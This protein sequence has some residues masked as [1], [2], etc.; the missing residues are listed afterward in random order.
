MNPAEL[1]VDPQLR[2]ALAETAAVAAGFGSPP[3]NVAEGRAQ[4]AAIRCFWNEGGP[5][6]AERSE[7]FVPGPLRQIPVVV[8]RSV[9]G[10]HPR[11]PVFVYLHG[12]GFKTGNAWANDRQMR[13]LCVAWGGTVISADYA[14]AP[15]HVF[16]AAVDETVALLSWLNE[17]GSA[18]GLDGE[19]IALGGSSAGAAI[20]FGAAVALGGPPWLRAAVGIVGAFCGDTATGSMQRYGDV[21]LFP[22]ARAV[23]SMFSDYLPRAKDREDPRANVLLADPSLFPPTFL[24]AA[25]YDVF[26][27]ASKAM[28]ER[29]RK[30][31]KLH[32][33]R[34][35]PRMSHLFFGLSKRVRCASDC[36][37]DIG[38]FLGKELP[39]QVPSPQRA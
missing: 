6:V 26:L 20:A 3:S 31:G 14:H 22:E 32:T 23:P 8:Y 25:E 38:S 19:R 16:P 5:E 12:G 9:A 1:E 2:A 17:H 37:A 4:A 21:G 28:G 15:E 39:V 7:R 36:I 30:A 33:L 34:V 24:A 35:Y 13:E 10:G 27:D 29:L 11:T 18:W